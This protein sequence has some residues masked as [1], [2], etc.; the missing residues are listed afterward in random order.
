MIVLVAAMLLLTALW[1]ASSQ[2]VAARA[3]IPTRAP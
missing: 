1:H 2:P 3:A